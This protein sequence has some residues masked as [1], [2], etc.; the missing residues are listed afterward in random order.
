[1]FHQPQHKS[2]GL[3]FYLSGVFMR[4]LYLVT[5]MLLCSAGSSFA[6][7]APVFRSLDPSMTASPSAPA[8]VQEEP[9]KVAPAAATLPVAHNGEVID[10]VGSG[11]IPALPL[12]VQTENGVSY[13]SGG[14]SDEETEQLRAQ[15]AAYNLR[16]LITAQGGE[17]V[18]D[19]LMI[20]K[21]AKGTALITVR[22]AGPCVYAQVPAGKYTVEITAASGATKT[23]SLTVPAKGVI[24]TQIR[25]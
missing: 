3:Y 18:S 16:L 4:H 7:G 10:S 15:E 13:L 2:C 19:V 22:D 24:K 20:L 12:E 1:L 23:V 25:V 8:A 14:I 17:F 11:A 5:A 9:A 21:D 6:Q